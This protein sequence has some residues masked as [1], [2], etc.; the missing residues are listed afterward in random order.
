MTGLPAEE[1][2]EAGGVKLFVQLV[3]YRSFSEGGRAM[4]L[5]IRSSSRLFQQFSSFVILQK[6]AP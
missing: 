4:P 6:I 3:P 1:Y 5:E 2:A